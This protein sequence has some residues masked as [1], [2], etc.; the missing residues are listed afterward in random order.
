MSQKINVDIITEYKGRQNLKTAQNDMSGLTDK[1]KKL[2]EVFGI[3]F[4]ADK[5]VEFG[6]AA[7]EAF[8][9]DQKSAAI[10]TQT[11]SNLGQAFANVP[12]EKFITS[13]SELNG[14]A[15]V[16]LRNS[17]DTLVRSTGDAAKAQDLLSLGT[18]ISAG[19]G[20]DLATVTTALAKAYGGNYAA[21]S[22][23]GAG[24]SKALLSTK[25]FAKMQKFLAQTFKGDASVAADSYQ[26]KI[27]R[28]KTSFEEFKITV[29]SG[30]VDAFANLGK[31]SNV[32]GFQNAMSVTATNIADMVDGL[33]KILGYVT[34]I[35]GKVDKSGGFWG[36]FW[37]DAA[38]LATT[39][40]AGLTT[41]LVG[42]ADKTSKAVAAAKKAMATPQG[43]FKEG[44]TS[45]ADHQKYM[46]TQADILAAKKA[47]LAIDNASTKAAKDK[48]ALERASLSLKLAGNTTDMQNIEI[49]AALQRGQTE[50]VTNVLLLQRAILNGNADQANIL[51]QEVLKANGLVMDVNGNISSLANAKDP[52][53]DWPPATA[54]AMAQ[55]KAIQDALAALKDKT[56][57]VTINTV[58]S[59]NGVPNGSIQ[60][61]ANQVTTTA[62]GTTGTGGLLLPSGAIAGVTDAQGNKFFAPAP[63]APSISG[64]VDLPPTAVGTASSMF[65]PNPY[66][67]PNTGSNQPVVV[68][69]QIDGQQ[70]T[71]TLVNNSA[72]GNPSTFAR[73]GYF[74]GLVA[75]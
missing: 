44:Y 53:K 6:K 17:F 58:T 16:D 70:I 20:K 22:K 67:A 2:G 3:T 57:T 25:D 36:S 29:G 4:A 34:Q 15:K 32:E 5:I 11:L 24:V 26:G 69:V 65:S 45:V 75:Q 47:Q 72:S 62:A 49:Q 12:V 42:A 38:V 18:D 27:N 41:K 52:F 54:A 37:N 14:I 59:T 68:N 55:L 48:L 19:T 50:Q 7:V 66:S 1:V 74:G 35:G 8:A 51:A 40:I 13:L 60:L 64:I 71:N 9:A 23:L 30:L 61:P 10:L 21:L 63:G 28:L 46:K 31:G 73:S 39:G 56:V 43:P 33:G